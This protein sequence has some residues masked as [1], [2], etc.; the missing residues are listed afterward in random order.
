MN[1]S[2]ILNSQKKGL[3]YVVKLVPIIKKLHVLKHFL[4]ASYIVID[5]SDS[6]SASRFSWD[7]KLRY[8]NTKILLSLSNSLKL[9]LK[10]ALVLRANEDYLLNKKENLNY[11]S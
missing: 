5:R 6:E 4:V 2:Q 8:N 11:I 10:I 7:E 9:V 3:G 1:V